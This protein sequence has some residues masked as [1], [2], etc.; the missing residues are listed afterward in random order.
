MD[1]QAIEALWLGVDRTAMI[2]NVD[3]YARSR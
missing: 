3:I 1:Q 2:G